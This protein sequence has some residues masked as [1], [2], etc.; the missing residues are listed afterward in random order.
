[1]TVYQSLNPSMIFSPNKISKSAKKF[2]NRQKENTR[3]NIFCGYLKNYLVNN[4][5]IAHAIH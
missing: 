2:F 1:M 5:T 4:N 3:K